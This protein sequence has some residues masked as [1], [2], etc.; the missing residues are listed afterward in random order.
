MSAAK[1][2]VF[3]GAVVAGLGLGGVAMVE[4]G[5]DVARVEVGARAPEFRA[6]DLGSGDTVTLKRY[7]N[8]VTLVN[9]AWLP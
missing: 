5:K 4:F 6:Y 7:R 9:I 8:T 2:W 1:Q 3:V